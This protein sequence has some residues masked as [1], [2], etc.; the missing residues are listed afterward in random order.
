MLESLKDQLLLVFRDAYAGVGHRN[1]NGPI[2][3]FQC[4]GKIARD[5]HHDGPGV[6]RQRVVRIRRHGA[7]RHISGARG[8]RRIATLDQERVRAGEIA[9]V[10]HVIWSECA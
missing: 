10:A 7:V 4:F 2:G 9:V 8:K 3:G 1:G 5:L 6:I